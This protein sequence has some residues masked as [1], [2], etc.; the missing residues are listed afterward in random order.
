[1]VRLRDISTGELR[2]WKDLS[3]RSAEPNPFLEPDG[4]MP[5]ARYLRF[6]AGIK[7]LLAEED[8]RA[9]ACL[10][11]RSVWKW[12]GFPYPFVTSEAS[13]TLECGTPLVDI[14]RGS[15]ALATIF[16][17]LAERRPIGR[18]RVLVLPQLTQ[19]GPVFE[20]LRTAA[21]TAD[22]PFVVFEGWERGFLVRRPEPDYE[23]LLSAR[24]QRELRRRRRRLTEMFGTEPI[25]VDRTADPA[26]VERFLHLEGSGY[27]AVRGIA[28][29]SHDG[30]SEYF[31]EICRRFAATGRL[32]LL[33]LEA[34]G[35]TLAMCVCLRERDGFFLFKVA[36]DERYAR[37]GPGV[38]I[39][40]ACMEYFHSSTDADWIDTGTYRDNEMSLRLFSDRRQTAG[41]FVPLSRSPLDM[42][43]IRS[44][45]ALRPVHR[46]I[47]DKRNP[48][49]SRDRREPNAGRVLAR[50]SPAGP[51]PVTLGCAASDTQEVAPGLDPL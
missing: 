23:R 1:V 18:S 44:F 40:A 38:L 36:Y 34:G 35:Q 10:P 8:G 22:L 20:A 37:Y 25:L 5:A 28:V 30:E 50:R 27:K 17:A 47:Y 43:A 11:I 6:G 39:Q 14:E 7:I 21:Q 16:S 48:Q 26:A 2:A 29:T 33:A 15:E 19:N 42:L 32:H 24:L 51:A 46:W 49:G 12:H 13:R 45:M 41:V 9:Y 31:A 4:V 3:S